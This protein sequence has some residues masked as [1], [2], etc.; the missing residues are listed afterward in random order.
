MLALVGFLRHF[1]ALTGK[2]L[3]SRSGRRRLPRAQRFGVGR[4]ES[5]AGEREASARKLIV[6]ARVC[7][8]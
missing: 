2:N 6:R 3:F 1:E 5:P 8:V 7:V 4:R